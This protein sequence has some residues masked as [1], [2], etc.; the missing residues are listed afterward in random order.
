MATPLLLAL[1]LIQAP[2]AAPQDQQ[3]AS[4]PTEPILATGIKVEVVEAPAVE[5]ESYASPMARISTASY[6]GV[7]PKMSPCRWAAAGFGGRLAG[8]DL[9][10]NFYRWSGGGALSDG[11]YQEW[12]AWQVRSEEDRFAASRADQGRAIVEANAAKAKRAANTQSGGQSSARTSPGST[13][14]AT[15]GRTGGGSSSARAV[16][17]GTSGGGSSAGAGRGAKPE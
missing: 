8:N 1:A 15:S 17:K 9:C 3:L 14:S 5:A 12:V 7:V 11:G 2:S 10:S 16:S 6:V 4:L 13:A